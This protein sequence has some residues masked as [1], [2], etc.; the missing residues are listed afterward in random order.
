MNRLYKLISIV[1][2]VIMIF[3]GSPCINIAYA[4]IYN[5]DNIRS[6]AE[7]NK[8]KSDENHKEELNFKQKNELKYYP[9][10]YK[11]DNESLI[12]RTG[13]NVNVEKV[14]KLYWASKEVEAQYLRS[15][16]SEQP[17]DQT[18][19]DDVLTIII[20]NNPNEYKMNYVI[21]GFATN[22]GGMYIEKLGTFYTYE[23]TPAQSIYTL[24]ELFRHE[25]TH[26]LQGRYVVPGMWGESEIYGNNRL[27]WYEEGGAEYFAGSTRTDGI[28]TRKSIVGNLLNKSAEELYS[29]SKTLNSTYN[30]GFEFY[31]YVCLLMSFFFEQ[32]YSIYD[33]LTGYIMKND[34]AGFDSY[35]KDLQNNNNINVKFQN[36][37]KNL[38]GQYSR[39]S[40]P[41][42]SD[43]YLNEHPNR[44]LDKVRKEITKIAKLN[45]VKSKK[46]HSQFFDTFEIRGTYNGGFSKGKLADMDN[47][48]KAA[49]SFLGELD[50]IG[51]N[52]YKT[53]TCYYV[54]YSVDSDNNYQ[55][56]VVFRGYL[57]NVDNNKE[58]GLPIIKINQENDIFIVKRRLYGE[59]ELSSCEMYYFMLSEGDIITI[60]LLFE[61][62][63]ITY[64][65][66]KADKFDNIIGYPQE[67]HDNCLTGN[68][69]LEQ[70]TY[71]ILVF[72]SNTEQ[73][74]YTLDLEYQSSEI[75]DPYDELT[76]ETRLI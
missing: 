22:N 63:D 29:L 37:I 61:G 65:L 14:K 54:N 11:F 10:T 30:D 69:F 44:N 40:I 31:N 70:G 56:D 25:F 21:N 3:N 8:Q 17:I 41:L 38:T 2:I 19:N 59:I 53:T 73:I 24:E 42:V 52:G 33:K 68:Y 51:W 23:R 15:I 43:D 12:I 58:N 49:D 13:E 47:M 75:N 6:L 48:R 7:D 28:K 62:N 72:K 50:K 27:T 35:I 26:Y 76:E 71:C 36:Y 64:V 18:H 20:Y 4:F 5:N 57:N 45:N 32:D 9:N 66:Y 67:C 60:T 39:L 16:G 55:F 1:L 74:N 46:N 34:I